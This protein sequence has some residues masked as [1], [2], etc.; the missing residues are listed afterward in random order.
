MAATEHNRNI[1]NLQ[2]PMSKLGERFGLGI[3]MYFDFIKFLSIA[4]FFVLIL[5]T[6]VQALV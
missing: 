3:Y 2:A 5:G 4:N 6:K 1:V